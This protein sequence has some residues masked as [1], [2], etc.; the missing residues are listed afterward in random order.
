VTRSEE[1]KSDVARS[2]AVTHYMGSRE[3]AAFF[4]QQYAQ[5]RA[6]LGDLGLAK[7]P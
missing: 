7:N 2:G 3:L 4:D 1:W 5:F 6:I